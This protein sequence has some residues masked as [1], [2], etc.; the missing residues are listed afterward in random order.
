MKPPSPPDEL[1]ERY[2]QA[3]A[4]LPDGLPTAPPAALHDRIMRAAREPTDA[5]NSIAL[6]AD[7]IPANLLKKHQNSV[8]NAEAANDSFWSIKAVA[9]IAVMGLS[10]LLWWQFEQGTLQEQEAAKSAKPSPT[11]VVTAPSAAPPPSPMPT[12]AAPPAA[13]I[14]QETRAEASSAEKKSIAAAP[15]KVSQE[16]AQQLAK[17]AAPTPASPAVTERAR[18]QDMAAARQ[19]EKTEKAEAANAEPSITADT[20]E[21]SA[22][23][24]S[25]MP[26]PMSKRFNAEAQGAL[27]Q[28]PAAAPAARPA[29]P[30]ATLPAPQPLLTAL[31]TRDATALRQALA[32]GI[33]P[34]ARAPDGNPALTQAVI[35]RWPEGVRI[36]LAAGADRNA[37]NSKGHTAADVALEL[38]YSDMTELLAT[39]R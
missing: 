19:T 34:N 39:A 35:Q 28:A 5:I 6:S 3:K 13:V 14:Q 37:K 32:Q 23:A 36:L 4:Q 29:A 7:S 22:A 12:P 18:T 26:A 8:H 15:S 20:T 24:K 31:Q 17:P 27:T 16:I 38:G 1:L 10:A 11:A 30:M 33:S 2:A 9:S 25:S 21:R